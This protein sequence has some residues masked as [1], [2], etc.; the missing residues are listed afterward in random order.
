MSGKFKESKLYQKIKSVNL[1]RS[2]IVTIVTVILISTAIIA[3]TVAANRAGKGNTPTD[4]V[5]PSVSDTAAGS[6][7]AEGEDEPSQEVIDKIPAFSLPATGVL[8]EKHDPDLQVYSSTLNDYRV[9]LG[10]DINTTE[11]APVYCAADGKVE[12][13]W[14]DVLM[15][16]CVAISHSGDACTIYKNLS[17]VF[18][19]GIEEGAK[20]TEGQLLGAVGDSA[21]VEIAKEPHLHFEMTVAGVAVDPLK[22]FTE[23]AVATLTSGDGSYEK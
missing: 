1:D 19:E 11:G 7:G 4:T 8:S 16:Y 12:K 10:I 5:A 20:V 3:I 13:I 9:H 17:K 6:V 22:H 18:A 2:A 21:M 23:N 14:E 15:G